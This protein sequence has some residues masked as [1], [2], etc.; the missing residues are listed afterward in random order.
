MGSG[1]VKGVWGQ[2]SEDL[3]PHVTLSHHESLCI[4]SHVHEEEMAVK[5][6]DMLEMAK[7]WRQQKDEWFTG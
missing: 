2:G 1:S 6:Y 3:G 4:S 7:L 5:L